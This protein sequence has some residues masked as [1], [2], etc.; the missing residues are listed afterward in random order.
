MQLNIEFFHTSNLLYLLEFKCFLGSAEIHLCIYESLSDWF[1][2]HSIMATR[3]ERFLHLLKL[4]A[5]VCCLLVLRITWAHC[6]THA[7]ETET[8]MEYDNA[9]GIPW[10]WQHGKQRDKRPDRADECVSQVHSQFRLCLVW[11]QLQLC[12]CPTGAMQ[13][14]QCNG[15]DNTPTDLLLPWT[16]I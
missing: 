8:S 15:T 12:D 13:P 5:I 11:S 4:F 9:S 3:N 2:L 1:T 14:T 6:T 7:P 16:L 10:P